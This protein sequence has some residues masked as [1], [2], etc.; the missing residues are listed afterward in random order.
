MRSIL[1]TSIFIASFISCIS[2]QVNDTVQK[3]DFGYVEKMPE[4][5]GGQAKLYQYIAANIQYP[6]EARKNNIRGKVTTQFVVTAEGKIT[7]IKIIQNLGFGCDEEAIR[8]LSSMPDWIPGSHNGK[9]VPVT[10]YLP[11]KF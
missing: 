8:V 3:F 5:P 7:N 10:F 6:E 2:A 4:F 1:I 11:V 9:P